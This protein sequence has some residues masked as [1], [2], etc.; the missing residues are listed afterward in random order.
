MLPRSRS[1]EDSN[2]SLSS[3]FPFVNHCLSCHQN[4]NLLEQPEIK[5]VI[6]YDSS[7]ARASFLDETRF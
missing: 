2:P 6:S 3:V 5:E 7:I 1:S 4:V